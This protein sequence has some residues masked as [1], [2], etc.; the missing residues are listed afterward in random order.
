M[1]DNESNPMKRVL[2]ILCGLAVIG[3]VTVSIAA[4]T[5]ATASWNAPVAY[6]DGSALPASDIANYTVSWGPA[7]GQAGPTG[8][9]NVPA[10]TTTA[11][12]PVACGTVTFTVS[13]TTTA[14]AHYPNATSSPS[15][16]VPYATGIACTPNPPSG[17]GVH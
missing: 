17:L 2:S 16:G 13:V 5:S 4:G 10:G 8:S 3:T 9:T 7:T 11:V 14:T 6:D 12:I 15:T 1:A